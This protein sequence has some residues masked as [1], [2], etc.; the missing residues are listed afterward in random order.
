MLLL[1]DLRLRSIRF[2][3]CVRCYLIVFYGLSSNGLCLYLRLLSFA[4]IFLLLL[5]DWSFLY[6][7]DLLLA[8]I[9]VTRRLRNQVHRGIVTFTGDHLLVIAWTVNGGLLDDYLVLAQGCT[10]K[11]F[12]SASLGLR[13]EVLVGSYPRLDLFWSITAFAFLLGQSWIWLSLYGIVRAPAL[14]GLNAE[15]DALLPFFSALLADVCCFAHRRAFLAWCF[16]HKVDVAP[17]FTVALHHRPAQ[18]CRQFERI[19]LNVWSWVWSLFR[20]ICPFCK[21]VQVLAYKIT[22]I[23][24]DFCACG[25]ASFLMKRRTVKKLLMNKSAYIVWSV[26]YLALL[27]LVLLVRLQVGLGV[28]NELTWPLPLLVLCS[29]RFDHRASID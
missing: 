13:L 4:V 1:L 29:D 20:S 5:L 22:F 21:F 3:L 7:F 11:W 25:G 18:A 26:V 12:H 27:I 6:R 19:L 23:Y 17:L 16:K 15:F 9:V 14:H 10:R 24:K 8:L 28:A 2:N